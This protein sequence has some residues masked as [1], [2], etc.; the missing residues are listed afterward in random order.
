MV[1][2]RL[3]V[4]E[5]ENFYIDNGPTSNTIRSFLKNWPQESLRLI[6]CKDFNAPKRGFISKNVYQVNHEDIKFVS[7]FVSGIR[8]VKSTITFNYDN[9]IKT[10]SLKSKIKGE[11]KE[12]FKTI[13][14]MLPYEIN[15]DLISFI[16]TFK[17][18]V[19]YACVTCY[20][21][22]RFVEQIS[23]KYNLPI[24]PHFMDDWLNV[25]LSRSCFIS[26]LFNSRFK[27]TFNYIMRKSPFGLCISDLMSQV[28]KER[29]GKEFYSLMNSVELYTGSETTVSK[30]TIEF[31]YAGSLYLNRYKLLLNFCETASKIGD[32]KVKLKICAPT[33][34]WTELKALFL[35]YD[36]VEYRG[37]VTP[38][39]LKEHTSSSDILVFVE[40]FDSTI[41][42]FTKLSLSTRIPEYLS[43]GK[44]ILAIGPY[45]QGSIQ[46]LKLNNAAFVATS[47][48][49]IRTE[50]KRIIKGDDTVNIQAHAKHLFLKN[51]LSINQEKKFRRLAEKAMGLSSSFSIVATVA[52][53]ESSLA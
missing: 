10:T 18:E 47:L 6:C 31:L 9:T 11:F 20:R 51:H 49:E 45:E 29:Y 27:R 1:Y 15:K 32:A 36:F 35:K 2:P 3:L 48:D 8:P 5:V 22:L 39:E 34:H 43:S 23:R 24:I 25:Y 14:S 46:Y 21:S 16:E 33:Q 19:I 42:E 50:I 7:K 12:S 53:G 17:P 30:K 13:Y 44:P 40:S 52:R 4:F 28:Y 26:P 41:L 38:E 37:F